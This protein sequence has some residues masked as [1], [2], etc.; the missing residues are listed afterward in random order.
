[1]GASVEVVGCRGMGGSK[2]VVLAGGVGCCGASGNVQ[3][4]RVGSG[5]G[6]DRWWAVDS[7]GVGW[8]EEWWSWY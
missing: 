5:G 1:M 7:R 8:P 6:W 2:G 4:S 3:L